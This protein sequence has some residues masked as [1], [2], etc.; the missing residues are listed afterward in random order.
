MEVA[1]R[2]VF[3]NRRIVC[4]GRPAEV[5]ANVEL[6]RVFGLDLVRP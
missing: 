4:L 1:D 3:L 6:R 5:I 2:I